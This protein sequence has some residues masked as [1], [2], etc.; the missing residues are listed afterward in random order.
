ML[1]YLHD[2]NVRD[3]YGAICIYW[4][5]SYLSSTFSLKSIQSTQD[6]LTFIFFTLFLQVGF[7]GIRGKGWQGDIAI[8]E[9]KI[10]NC[11]GGGGGAG[12]GGGGGGAGAGGG[13]GSGS[14]KLNGIQCNSIGCDFFVVF[15]LLLCPFYGLSSEK[16]VALIK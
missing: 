13:G 1:R 4:Y 16:S 10:V 15:C 7:E 11:G 8:D 3:K 12:G 14:G 5:F 9:V 6:Y 2:Y